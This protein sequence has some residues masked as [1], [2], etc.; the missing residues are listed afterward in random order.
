[1][2]QKIIK[3]LKKPIMW[4]LQQSPK[5]KVFIVLIMVCMLYLFF[6]I[7]GAPQ[8]SIPKVN[9]LSPE[10]RIQ[11][12]NM[13]QGKF[14]VLKMDV[15]SVSYYVD[16]MTKLDLTPYR[17]CYTH[18]GDVD[19]IVDL[20]QATCEITEKGIVVSVPEPRLDEDTMNIRPANLKRA[21]VKRGWRTKSRR[22]DVDNEVKA[23][24]VEELRETARVNAP[25]QRAKK[26]VV[27][28]L[29]ALY[30][31]AGITNVDVEFF[32]NMKDVKQGDRL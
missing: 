26:Q 17:V 21:W 19:V 11:Q 18:K 27:C 16:K 1:M 14:C 13:M 10:Q 4:F 28:F 3:I 24:I 20:T 8:N 2:K 30:S 32:G 22:T 29:Q 5:D 23:R 9:Q 15:G 25:I 31:S 12:I 7:N 6:T